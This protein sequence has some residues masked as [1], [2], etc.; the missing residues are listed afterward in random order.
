MR[1]PLRSEA[2]AFRFLLLTIG[3]FALIVIGAA[4]DRWVGVAVFVALTFVALYLAFFRG[5]PEPP[6]RTAP[7]VPS[8]DGETRILVIANETIGGKALTD[9]IRQKS[10][11]VRAN[12]LVVAPALVTPLRHLT[13]D[14]D[15]GRSTAQERLDASLATLRSLG[16]AANGEV[17]DAQPLQAIE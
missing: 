7:T 6:A 2:E 12:V 5:G 3:Y 13:S 4:I 15:P 9:V 10:E 11:G 1:N 17:G 16:V 8:P 14:E